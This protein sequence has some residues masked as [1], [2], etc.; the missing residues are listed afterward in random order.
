MRR[1][2]DS[3]ISLF[4]ER[5]GVNAAVLGRSSNNWRSF[6]FIRGFIYKFAVYYLSAKGTKLLQKC[7]STGDASPRR[8]ARTVCTGG[9]PAGSARNTRPG[10]LTSPNDAV[11][12][13]MPKPAE[14]NHILVWMSLAYWTGR[15]W[16][17][18][19]AHSAKN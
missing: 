8:H 15:G 3:L 11:V 16:A 19:L 1:Q 2:G 12:G 7:S 13:A 9:N 5:S 4:T 14:I 17:P 6:V 10:R 18:A